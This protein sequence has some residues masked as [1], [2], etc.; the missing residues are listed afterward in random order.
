VSFEDVMSTL[1]R[2]LVATEALAAV[3]A[4]LTLLQSPEAGHPDVVGALRT[5]SAAAGLDD[6]DGMDPEQRGMLIA[7]IRLALHEA[8]DLMDEP[9]RE[10]SW[11]FTDPDILQGWGRLSAMVPATLTAAVPELA[12][13]RSFLDVGC[14]IGLL[15][16]AAT[17]VWPDATVVGIDVWGP[18]LE[19]A[20][21]NVRAAG[22]EQRITIRDQDVTTLDDVDA[23]DCV[24]L[25]TIFMPE[26]VLTAA[27][28]RL[29]AALRPGGWVV[30]ARTA[31]PP[32]QLAQATAALRTVRSG[33]A[34][35][36]A[37]ALTV[38]LEDLGCVDVT[39]LPR[40]GPSPVEYVIGHR[41]AT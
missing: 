6:L 25:P 24:W 20:R 23:Y 32:D 9:G 39:V 36:D 19:A 18:S 3:G 21:A 28:P 1:S 27:M 37:K 15:A 14:G 12:G 16:I 8:I 33:G 30:L 13:I 26:P 2:W 29:F 38:A 11:T 34:D 22:L 35:H 41:P 4:Q 5:I 31:A 7:L 40:Q 17:R 10:P